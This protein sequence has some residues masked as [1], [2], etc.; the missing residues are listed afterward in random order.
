MM[1][2]PSCSAA[3]ANSSDETR[4]EALRLHTN[5][6]ESESGRPS[7]PLRSDPRLGADAIGRSVVEIRT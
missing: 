7:D 2:R 1:W 5:H 6:E 3:A 4:A